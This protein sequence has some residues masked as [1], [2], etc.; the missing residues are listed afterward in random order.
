MRCFQL[1]KTNKCIGLDYHFKIKILIQVNNKYPRITFPCKIKQI[2]LNNLNNLILNYTRPQNP[3]QIFLEKSRNLYNFQT[4]GATR[5]RAIWNILELSFGSN[6]GNLRAIGLKVSEFWLLVNIFKTNKMII[7]LG[8]LYNAKT[9][10][11][12]IQLRNT[13]CDWVQ[14]CLVLIS[15]PYL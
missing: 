5:K 12:R 8:H 2:I 4:D 15:S 3:G 9:T 7:L 14:S 6:F 11:I 10:F 1:E 13:S